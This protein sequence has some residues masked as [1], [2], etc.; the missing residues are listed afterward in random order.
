MST[1]SKQSDA[2]ENLKIIARSLKTSPEIKE[3]IWK[4]LADPNTNLVELHS[5]VLRNMTIQRKD[6]DS[7]GV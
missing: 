4:A 2:R 1:E 5:G 6:R 3:R 7:S